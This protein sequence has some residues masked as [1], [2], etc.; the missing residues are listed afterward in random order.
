MQSLK[1]DLR[2]Y[3]N[4]SDPAASRLRFEELLGQGHDKDLTDEILCQIARTW[5]LEG[6]YE[7]AHSLLESVSA[8]DDASLRSWA[9][10]QLERGRVLNSS[11]RKLEARPLFEGACQSQWPDLRID[12]L[13][14]L[15]I[16]SSGNEAL[17]LNRKALQ[18]AES[19]VMPQAQRWV[20]SLGN[21]LGW[22]L[23][24]LGQLDEALA[25]FKKTEVFFAVSGGRQHHIAKWAIARCLRSMGR[26]REAIEI[27][28]ELKDESDG[29][30]PEELGENYLA[31]GQNLEAGEAFRLAFAQL[32]RDPWVV[33]NEAE[34]LCRLKNLA[35]QQPP[36]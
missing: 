13:H 17:E 7:Q 8:P 4:F 11:G 20:G 27:L 14:M 15:A 24:D 34:K 19:A 2:D 26:H 21:N 6:K 1:L 32:S 28:L 23:L 36:A 18:E 31:L 22:N 3:W 35:E 16:V 25:A 29:Y 30:V 10:W 12:A 5:G 9:C 33:E